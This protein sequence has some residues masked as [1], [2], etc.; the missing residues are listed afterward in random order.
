MAA[1]L[2][3]AGY[4]VA[5]TGLIDTHPLGTSPRE[6]LE[7]RGAEPDLAAALP[8]ELLA[9]A[10]ALV[11]LVHAGFDATRSLA[12]G[13]VDPNYAG[14]VTLITADAGVSGEVLADRWRRIRGDQELS[15][16]HLPFDHAG[17]VTPAGWAA[18]A[19][20]LDSHL[21]QPTNHIVGNTMG[22]E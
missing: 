5:F 16:H 18:I 11:E 1:Q 19:P 12:S 2:V 17:L 7:D 20:L 22:V 13:S 21:S 10:P 4:T 6:H 8:P 15:V 3:T 14:S 9:Q